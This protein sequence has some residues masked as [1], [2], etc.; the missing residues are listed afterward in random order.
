[1]VL[2][3]ER[4]KE[5]TKAKRQRENLYKICAKKE[6]LKG[7]FFLSWKCPD[8]QNS[9]GLFYG[10]RKEIGQSFSVRAFSK[11]SRA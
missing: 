6:S 10:K 4:K 11:K 1:M 7:S 8:F 2:S 5:R 3:F 9:G